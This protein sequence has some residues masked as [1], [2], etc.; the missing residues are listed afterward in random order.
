VDSPFE[1][2]RPNDEANR[3]SRGQNDQRRRRDCITRAKDLAVRGWVRVERMVR[4]MPGFV[5]R[6][7]KALHQLFSIVFE[8]VFDPPNFD[9]SNDSKNAADRWQ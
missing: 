7:G 1:G 6:D 4:P 8:G 3:P 2:S 9:I 5:F